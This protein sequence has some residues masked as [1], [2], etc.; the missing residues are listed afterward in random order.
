MQQIL[1]FKLLEVVQQ[2]ILGM[3]GNVIYCFV[4]NL[5]NSVI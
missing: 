2:H 4:A 1:T 5:T 3:V